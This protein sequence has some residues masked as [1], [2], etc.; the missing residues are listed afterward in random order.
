VLGLDKKFPDSATGSVG[1]I[2]LTKEW[3]EYSIDLA[4]KDLTRIKT[5]FLW[6]LDGQGTPVVFFLDDIRFE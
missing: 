6:T 4:G 3:L 5:G 2:K 1:P